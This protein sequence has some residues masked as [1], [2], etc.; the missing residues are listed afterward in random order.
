M[1]LSWWGTLTTA[2]EE[3]L[4][5][6][7]FSIVKGKILGISDNPVIVGHDMYALLLVPMNFMNSNL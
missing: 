7:Y 2:S 5:R 1:A 4:D 6:F 3:I